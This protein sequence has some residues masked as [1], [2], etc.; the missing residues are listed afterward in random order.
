MISS[1]DVRHFRAEARQIGRS[2]EEDSDYYVTLLGN[3]E[4]DSD[5]L[6]FASIDDD[7]DCD[8]LDED[9]SESRVEV[10]SGTSS[11]VAGEGA[12]GGD[13]V[14]ASTSGLMQE[15]VVHEHDPCESEDVDDLA[16]ITVHSRKRRK[17]KHLSPASRVRVESG[18]PVAGRRVGVPKG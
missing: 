13:I 12:G 18:E 16:V 10:E 6:G 14:V 8:V 9:V 7:T 15:A 2:A 11:N 1:R 4:I 3:I 17:Q 5:N